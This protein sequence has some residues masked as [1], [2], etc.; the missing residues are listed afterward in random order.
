MK[1]EDVEGTGLHAFV[2]VASS[3]SRLDAGV[4]RQAAIHFLDFHLYISR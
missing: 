3:T 2:S 4:P 1:D